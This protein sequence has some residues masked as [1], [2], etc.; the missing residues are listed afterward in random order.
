M[1]TCP[2]L[3]NDLHENTSWQSSTKTV[4]ALSQGYTKNCRVQKCYVHRYSSISSIRIKKLKVE[5]TLPKY[6][7]HKN[8]QKFFKG[9]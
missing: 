3:P 9:N 7:H 6:N 8:K 5:Q 4:R 1:M 2:L